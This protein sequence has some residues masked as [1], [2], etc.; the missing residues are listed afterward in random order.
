MIST[1]SSRSG[2]SRSP[3]YRVNDGLGYNG[4]EFLAY[5]QKLYKENKESYPNVRRPTSIKEA[6][7]FVK[8]MGYSVYHKEAGWNWFLI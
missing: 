7:S 8:K 4:K 2:R 6:T 1:M 3:M 5:A